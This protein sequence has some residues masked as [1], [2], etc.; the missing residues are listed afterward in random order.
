MSNSGKVKILVDMYDELIIDDLDNASILNIEA[1]QKWYSVKEYIP[2]N[3]SESLGDYCGKYL[4]VVERLTKYN[5]KAIGSTEGKLYRTIELCYWNDLSNRFQDNN[6]EFVKVTHWTQIPKMPKHNTVQISWD[7]M[8]LKV[9]F[10]VL[11]VITH[12]SEK[13]ESIEGMYHIN[14]EFAL[15]SVSFDIETFYAV[16]Y[17]GEYE[18]CIFCVFN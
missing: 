7:E 2:S 5:P 6:N 1:M 4:C 18:E 10:G 14:K 11:K 17:D 9:G 13:D 8:F 15:S 12:L 16:K 3:S